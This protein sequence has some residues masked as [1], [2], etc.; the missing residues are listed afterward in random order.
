MIERLLGLQDLDQVAAG[1]DRLGKPDSVFTDTLG[2]SGL[3]LVVE[4]EDGASIP[5]YGPVIIVGNHPCGFDEGLALP[6][7]VESVRTDAKTLAHDWFV[8]Y[9]MLSRHMILVDPGAKNGKALRE[10]VAHL[11]G[12]GALAVFPAGS[13]ARPPMRSL[14]SKEGEWSAGLAALVKLSGATIVPVGFGG[15]AGVLQRIAASVDPRLG[16]LFLARDFLRRRGETIY[17]RVGCPISPNAFL[18]CGGAAQSVRHCRDVV[19]TLAER[20]CENERIGCAV[21]RSCPGFRLT[22]IESAEDSLGRASI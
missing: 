10:S 11:K 15:T 19:L 4:M 1:V 13:V 22:P 3:S 9:P 8:R 18:R 17:A 14:V 7:L 16:V 20:A 2:A 21:K 5:Q 6:S 12:G